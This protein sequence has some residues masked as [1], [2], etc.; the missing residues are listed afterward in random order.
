MVLDL[1]EKEAKMDKDAV[2]IKIKFR[3]S[4]IIHAIYIVI[5]LI[6]LVLVFYNPFAEFRCEKNLSELTVEPVPEED[7]N[8]PA[9]E[10]EEEPA[11]DEP[12]VETEEP[13]P[14]PETEVELSGEAGLEIGEVELNVNKTRIESIM[15]TIN[16]DKGLFTPYMKIYWYGPSDTDAVK[17]KSKYE[18]EFSSLVPTGTTSKK[19]DDEIDKKGGRELT[20]RYLNLEPG[21]NKVTFKIELYDT[22]DKNASLDSKIKS[23]VVS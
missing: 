5:I 22:S 13:A 8:E 15:I 6:L 20:G 1:G 2:E 11:A 19:L 16:N 7:V 18:Y 10:V 3:K 17:Q 21:D 12:A 9:V 4:W 23:V 14:E